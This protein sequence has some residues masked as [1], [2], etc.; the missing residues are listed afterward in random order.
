MGG[1]WLP[2]ELALSHPPA[3][4][5]HRMCKEPQ[6]AA[7]EAMEMG[8]PSSQCSCHWLSLQS[9]LCR[10]PPRLPQRAQY[11]CALRAVGLACSQ[12]QDAAATTTRPAGRQ[13]RAAPPATMGCTHGG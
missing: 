4:S 13:G 7:I 11:S 8:V 1:M 6:A 9:L 2:P 5:S 12:Q 10:L 3:A